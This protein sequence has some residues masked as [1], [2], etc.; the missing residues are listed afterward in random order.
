MPKMLESERD[1]FLNICVIC[2][3]KY[4]DLL[5]EENI[6]LDEIAT[7]EEK[8]ADT[9]EDIAKALDSFKQVYKQWY[10]VIVENDT[11]SIAVKDIDIILKKDKERAALTQICIQYREDKGLKPL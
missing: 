1:F 2:T 3:A 9:A 4:L 8:I 5:G 6:T 7:L 10:K 11:R